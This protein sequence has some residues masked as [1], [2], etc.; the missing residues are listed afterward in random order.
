MLRRL[1]WFVLLWLAG[2]ATLALVA[3]LIRLVLRTP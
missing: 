1:G 2:V 3:T